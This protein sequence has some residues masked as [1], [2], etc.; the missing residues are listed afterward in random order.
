M[1]MGTRPAAEEQFRAALALAPNFFLA[2][3]GLARIL[4]EKGEDAAEHWR[5]GF[6]GF[7]TVA[8]RFRGPPSAQKLLLLVSAKLGNMATRRWIDD[9]AF[10]VTEIFVEFFDANAPLPPHDLIVNAI[11]DA[12]LCAAGFALRRTAAGADGLSGRQSAGARAG[13]R[14][15]FQRFA[16]WRNSRRGRAENPLLRSAKKSCRRNA[17]FP[18]LLR[19]PGFH[20]GRHFS[21]V[22]SF[23]ALPDVLA[24]LP[25]ESLSVIDISMHAAPTVFRGSI[26]SCSSMARSFPC[27]SRYRKTGWCITFPPPWRST[28]SFRAEERRFLEGM[29]EFSG[30]RAMQALRDIERRWGSIMPASISAWRAMVRSAVRSQRDHEPV[31]ARS[32]A[33]LGLSP[34]GDRCGAG[35]G[36]GDD[37]FSAKLGD[38]IG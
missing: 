29:P 36:E 19:A 6:D 8:R 24:S 4:S 11:G 13:D 12:D 3:Q 35:G 16:S 23:A 21:L 32:R 28:P 18:L 9:R 37:Y 20:T 14:Q 2:H 1:R 22:E 25:G 34:P 27:I 33:D 31:S 5:K 15:G 30:E 26:A 38:H 7:A 10:A 17:S